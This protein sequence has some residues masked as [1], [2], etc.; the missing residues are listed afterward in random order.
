MAADTGNFNT[1]GGSPVSCAAG[2]AFLDVI[3]VEG[4]QHNALV[5]GKYLRQRLVELRRDYPI[6]VEL[7]GAGL[8]LGVDALKA[9]GCPDRKLAS[10]VMN[11]LRRNGV[12][13][14]TRGPN[15]NVLKIRPPI[16]FY[17]DHAE[18]LLAALANALD[19]CV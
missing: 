7:H 3:E 14:G 11:H 5:M 12:L 16:V 9:G 8:L 6:L 1:F 4:L 13:I 15:A 2:L 10:R 17:R 19:Q 18:L